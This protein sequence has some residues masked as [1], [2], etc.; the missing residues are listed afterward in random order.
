MYIIIEI[1]SFCLYIIFKRQKKIKEIQSSLL[2]FILNSIF[3]FFF[4]FYLINLNN[5]NICY[6]I[7]FIMLYKIGIF[8]FFIWVSDVYN[9]LSFNNI[10]I[11]SI[12]PKF[13]F[14][15]ILY[16]I[17]YIDFSS[18]ALISILIACILG[19][20]QINIKRI[21]AYSS[22]INLS[23]ILILMLKNGMISFYYLI[24]YSFFLIP[25]LN[26]L[27]KNFIISYAKGYLNF[28]FFIIIFSIITISGIPPLAGFFL[29]LSLFFS[30]IVNSN[31]IFLILLISGISTALFI[32]LR[33]INIFLFK[34]TLIYKS[35]IDNIYYNTG[36]IVYSSGFF[37]LLIPFIL[38]NIF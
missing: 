9:G 7:N 35:L 27:D 38:K 2:Y 26:L 17:N 8:P 14:F 18:L 4:I 31:W 11:L 34:K 10:A 1:Q 19:L 22:I 37:I 20:N 15:L 21:L 12:L 32:Y 28:N 30:I 6:Y 23:I 25:I 13:I 16:K 24:I 36:W 33:L 5:N 3:S 29:K